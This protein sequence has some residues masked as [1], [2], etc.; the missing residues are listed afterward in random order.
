MDKMLVS[1]A[2]GKHKQGEDEESILKALKGMGC[3]EAEAKKV[4]LHCG[5]G[6]EAKQATAAPQWAG[7]S[8]WVWLAIPPLIILPLLIAFVGISIAGLGFFILGTICL[9]S[10]WSM[11]KRYANLHGGYAA[12]FERNADKGWKCVIA[13]IVGLVLV[14]VGGAI[15]FD[16]IIKWQQSRTIEERN[17]I[18]DDVDQ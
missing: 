18:L 8:M 11:L 7:M 17:Q 2:L 3:E 14:I 15:S 10:G 9:R 16:L 1:F 4:L 6:E 12:L 13:M 5:I